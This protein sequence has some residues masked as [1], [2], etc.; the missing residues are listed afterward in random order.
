MNFDN[1]IAYFLFR[2]IATFKK[3]IIDYNIHV[4]YNIFLLC[5]CFSVRFSECVYI[6]FHFTFIDGSIFFIFI[7]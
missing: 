2:I 5:F 3:T 1:I 7:I 6:L 4:L